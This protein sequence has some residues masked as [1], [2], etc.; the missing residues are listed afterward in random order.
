M[1]DEQL[2]DELMGPIWRGNPAVKELVMSAIREV[3]HRTANKAAQQT[4]RYQCNKMRG[5]CRAIADVIRN[6]EL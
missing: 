2:A 1:N 6:E 5:V 3:R 4:R